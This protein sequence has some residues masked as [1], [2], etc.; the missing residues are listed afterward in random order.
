MKTKQK[1]DWKAIDSLLIIEKMIFNGNISMIK[2][3][4]LLHILET[5]V[6]LLPFI[7]LPYSLIYW[8]AVAV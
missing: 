6:F 7:Y 3:F 8:K 2:R 5:L 4:L 1:K